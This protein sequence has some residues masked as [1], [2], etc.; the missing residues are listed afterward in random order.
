MTG[1]KIFILDL[2]KSHANFFIEAFAQDGY[3]AI[4]F[5]TLV[6]LDSSYSPDEVLI[7]LLNYH[8][9]I[10]SERT[11]VIT[12][13]K[14]VTNNKTIVYQMPANAH[15]RL[16]FYELGAARVY[17]S[18]YSIE[19]VLYSSKWLMKCLSQKEADQD[20][21][22]SGALQDIP[23]ISLLNALGKVNRSGI[24]K[25]VTEGNSG[26][27]YF[28]EGD[29]VDAQVGIYRGLR[30]LVH[31]M[32]WDYGHFIFSG[33]EQPDAID[34]IGLS[35]IA[36]QLLGEDYRRKYRLRMT[37][38]CRSNSV[39]RAKNCGDLLSLGIEVN[40]DFIEHIQRP[41]PIAELLENPFYTCP[42]TI[43]TLSVLKEHGFLV[44]SEPLTHVLDQAWPE[45]SPEGTAIEPISWIHEDTIQMKENL[46][47]EDK[48]NAKLFVLSMQQEAK[49][50]FIGQIA[51]TR[52]AVR[53]QKNFDVAQIRFDSHLEIFIIGMILTQTSVDMIESISEGLNGYIFLIDGSQTEQFEYY[54]YLMNQVLNIRSA[55]AVMAVSHLTADIDLLNIRSKFYTPAP[56]NW[57][58]Y[59]LRNP[60]S[61]RQVLLSIKPITGNA[62]NQSP[63]KDNTSV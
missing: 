30:A 38:L 18:S 45:I 14:R 23:L 62:S 20:F 4:Q 31:M 53:S 47:I 11:A 5:Q 1:N 10:N 63:N 48:K 26:K 27:I 22:S 7:V 15:R 12:F 50:D 44:I 35:N 55:P 54:N 42:E 41:H 43:D 21:Y 57:M 16:A 28:D 32:F 37:N 6:H 58:R 51:K 59:I 13:F 49:A 60:Q 29:I 40:R 2:E 46:G 25:I 24:L 9:I 33:V 34:H 61:T 56:L 8:S 36:I 52:S 39:V 19:E 17:D 3:E